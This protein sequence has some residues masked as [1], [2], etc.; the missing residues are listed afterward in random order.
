MMKSV[1]IKIG[2]GKKCLLV[3][4]EVVLLDNFFFLLLRETL[5]L[6]D[7]KRLV[8][9]ILRLAQEGMNGPCTTSQL[10][11]LL[12]VQIAGVKRHLAEHFHIPFLGPLCFPRVHLVWLLQDVVGIG[13][14]RHRVFHVR[15]GVGVKVLEMHT[16]LNDQLEIL[17]GNLE[18]DRVSFTS[19]L[20]QVVDGLGKAS[21]R[22]HQGQKGL[23]IHSLFVSGN[24]GDGT[25]ANVTHVA[26]VAHV[27]RVARI[28]VRSH[29]GD[30]S[31]RD[32]RKSGGRGQVHLVGRRV[33]LHH[34]RL[35]VCV[36]VF[37]F[38]RIE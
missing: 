14:L 9:V 1:S 30:G 7:A 21:H 31:Q 5:V 38:C 33:N 34:L 37:Y 24:Q 29:K 36:H 35:R 22:R 28:D 23:A 13:K 12:N 17:L 25:L 26:N 11:Q 6:R 15:L 19:L 20:D 4:Q 32:G 8:N 18:R 2:L 3:L 16:E 10:E 27:A